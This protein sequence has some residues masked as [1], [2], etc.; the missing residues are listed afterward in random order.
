M[1]FKDSSNSLVALEA[2]IDPHPLTVAP[3]T[4][5]VDVITLVSQERIRCKLPSLNFSSDSMLTHDARASC[6]LVVDGAQLVGL[7][8]ERDFVRFAVEGM[9]LE[10]VKVG[11]VMR[12][13]LITLRKSDFRDIFTVLNLFRQ[14][15][16]RHLPILNNSGQLLGIVMPDTIVQALQ[17]SDLFQLRRVAEVMTTE[18]IHASPTASVLDLAQLMVEHQVSCVVITQEMGL[19]NSDRELEWSI[20][21]TP[22]PLQGLR[23]PQS[24]FPV[25]IV[26]E[27]DLVQ[28]QS[29]KLDFLTLQ[30]Q[31]VMS[32]P[33][34]CLNPQESLWVA[35]QEMQRQSV[36][37]LVVCG[38]QGELLG[39]ITQSSLLRALDPI[40]MYSVIQRLQKEVHQLQT[41]KVELLHKRHVE[42]EKQVQKRTAKLQKQA[43]T[44]IAT[45][46]TVMQQKQA[47]AEERSLIAAMTDVIIVYDRFG[48]CRKI[49]PTNPN[50]L[51][52]PAAEQIN[53][54]VHE[55]M[56]KAHADLRL[57]YIQ[58][59]LDTQET[60]HVEYSL[61]IDNQD[62]WFSANVSP[63]SEKTVIW[64]ERDITERKLAEE[65]L[66][67]SG[68]RFRATFE[69]AA[70]GIAHERWDGGFV[71]LNQK[72]CQIVGYTDAELLTKT[73][74]DI[75]H[76]EDVDTDRRHIVQ[77]LAGEIE[78]FA[79]EKRCLR[80]DGSI[81]WVNI[82]VSLIEQPSGD[83]NYFIKVIEDITER[84]QVEAALRK[85]EERYR[86]I[87]EN[88]D[89]GLFQATLDGRYLSVNPALARI[90]GYNSPEEVIASLRNINQQLYVDTHHRAKFLALMQANGSVSDF[91]SQV[92]RQDNSIIWI[93][94][95]AHIVRNAKGEVLYYEG[96]VVDITERKIW[97][98]A[99]R[100]QQECTEDLLLNILPSPIAHRLKRAESNIADSFASVTVLFADLVNFTE[101]SA[102][103][104]PTELV[105]LL[106]NIFSVFDQLSEKHGL[107]KIKTIGDAYMVVG[108]LPTPRPDHACAVA[109]MALEMR[110]EIARFRLDDG[111]PFN[112]RI[113]INTGPVVAGVIGTKKFTYDLWG[114]TVNVASRMESMAAAG[115]IQV[116]AAT[117]ELLKDKYLFEQRGAISVKGKGP[118]ITYWLTG[119][120]V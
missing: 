50:F 110:R 3:E 73:F 113:G 81:V 96:S 14:H 78:T 25:G 45:L 99:L 4:L 9:N 114:D 107:E 64:V 6:V 46:E 31:M 39:I 72:F 19:L 37:R 77:L 24:L 21:I 54:T 90:Y 71:R 112:L 82:T 76:P 67:E 106:N 79:I 49:A 119:R 103:I 85:A 13:R 10:R 26:T 35:H 95:N 61:R 28:L 62:L 23:V 108:G 15:Q 16:I 101:L 22:Y 29:L 8:S 51:V 65:A 42:L 87:F 30:A 40:E 92:Y 97:E 38:N 70:V 100:Y 59:A 60:L 32:S 109:E 18:V 1:Q 104:P 33:L 74:V 27:R 120:K 68:E 88:T 55:S 93:S 98:E 17:A 52:K 56:P 84:K 58:R 94:E 44:A 12:Q 66:L 43:Q 102:L 116:T 41:D 36:R 105:Y 48:R 83:P 86:S 91:E 117:Y 118:M 47:E 20:P 80:K 89:K 34:F 7:L 57:S 115:G 63:L 53:R 69:Q 75:T 5:L 111:E 2:A 11:E